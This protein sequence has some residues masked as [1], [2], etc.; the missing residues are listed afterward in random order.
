MGTNNTIIRHS[1][2]TVA[3]AAVAVLAGLNAQAGYETTVLADNPLAFYPLNLSVDN[4]GTATDASGNGNSAPYYN[5]YLADG[6]TPYI[7]NSGAFSADVQSY[8]DLGAVANTAILQFTGP[9]HS[10]GLGAAL[11]FLPLWRHHRQGV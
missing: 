2:R 5:V 4:A 11:R 7:T 8:V 3:A 9:H 1:L 6:P 10:R